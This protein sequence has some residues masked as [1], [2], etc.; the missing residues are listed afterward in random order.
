MNEG[1]FEIV[2]LK[3][4]W[5]PINLVSP[6]DEET[7]RKSILGQLNDRYIRKGWLFEGEIM[8]GKDC[9]F[10]V[11]RLKPPGLN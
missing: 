2:T 11:V 1:E 9:D 7:K 4:K 8:W 10:A 5:S 3:P 6:E